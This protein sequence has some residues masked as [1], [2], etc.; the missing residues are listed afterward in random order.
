M[1]TT[2]NPTRARAVAEQVAERETHLRHLREQA[3]IDEVFDRADTAK[4][5][6]PPAQVLAALGTIT[7]DA[8]G[9][10][11]AGGVPLTTA[12]QSYATVNPMAVAGSV[13]EIH[14]AGKSSIRSKADLIDPSDPK[15]VRRKVDYIAAHGELQYARLPAVAVGAAPAEPTDY[16][17]Y[18]KLPL[19]ERAK[20]AGEKG[21]A[22][23]TALQ[24]GASEQSR[25]DK[26][27]GVPTGSKIRR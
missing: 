1:S 9:L 13:A 16:A 7:F 20:L 17:Q 25:Y 22:W 24:R 14:D 4:F 26:L 5:K 11:L 19:R 8:D 12:L 3:T 15:S 23:I 21:P 6:I 18:L 2:E 27:V 10:P